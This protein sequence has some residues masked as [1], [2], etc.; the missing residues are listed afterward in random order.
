MARDRAAQKEGHW[1]LIDQAVEFLRTYCATLQA[2]RSPH[3]RDKP[4]TV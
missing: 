4:I 3:L 2:A 1:F